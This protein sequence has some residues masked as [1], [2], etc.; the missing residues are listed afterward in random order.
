MMRPTIG[1]MLAALAV[2]CASAPV[3][4]PP[5]PVVPFEQ[6]ISWVVRL[7]D[8]RM[9]AD[10]LPPPPDEPV[11][12]QDSRTPVIAAAPP[13]GPDLLRLL[14]DSEARVRRR[15][16]LAVGRVGLPAGVSPLLALLGDNEPEVRQMAA[17]AL[18]L[19]GDPSAT[20]P[21]LAALA[22]PSPLVQG[23]AAEALG[24]IGDPT[25]ADAIADLAAQ[26]VDS[27]ALLTIPSD[28]SDARRDAPESVYRLALYALARLGNY[29]AL[30]RAALDASGQPVVRWWPVAYALQR[31]G[32]PRALPALRSLASDPHPYTRSF[33]V[34]ALGA[35]KDRESVPLLLP[36]VVGND[37]AVAIQAVEALGSIGD[38]DAASALVHIIQ[39][40]A[41]EPHLRLAAISAVGLVRGEGATDV[42]IDV[43]ADRSPPIRAAAL[44]S[45]A[46]L[47][48]QGFV[49][50]LSGLDPDSHWS[51]RAALA[52]TLAT[53]KAE[54]A[55]PRLQS[56]L[57]DGDQRVI[58][59]VLR[60]LTKLRAPNVAEVLAT[61]LRSDD[62]AVRAAA[63]AGIGELL[64]AEGSVALIEAYRGA[65][66]GPSPVARK[67]ILSALAR[68]GASLATPV[69]TEALEDEDWSVRRHAAELLA[70]FEPGTDAF[71]HIRPAPTHWGADIY[72]APRV[73]NPQV[74][75]QVYVE[76]E[77]GIIQIE[78]AVLD[79]PLTVENFIAL[80]SG[81]WYDGMPFHRVVAGH[82]VQ[83]GD[84][85]GDGEGGPGYTIRDELNQLPFL[86]GAVGMALNGPDS[87]GSQF[88]IALSPQPH[89][90]GRFTVFGRVLSGMEIVDQIEP[91]DVIRRVR[92]WDGDTLTRN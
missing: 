36:M 69:L 74:S 9:L 53:L 32:D 7:E 24:L 21:L 25:A 39:D 11:V 34:R 66:T 10:P 65:R 48:P 35:L 19:I 86:R 31:I 70:T 92:I 3:L 79:A 72:E 76:T 43:L 2:G 20:E 6:K 17:F 13:P 87:G 54:A 81:G 68:Y 83:H 62:V 85:R 15:A 80:A 45:L 63:A 59:S 75:T 46:R 23:S 22:D 5:Q 12:V 8:Q 67:A 14:T 33:A 18:G 82:V 91:W 40:P 30:A 57:D 56:M 41:S 29:Q 50:I 37:R 47:D 38:A 26:L 52:E 73:V 60:A 1:A 90:N 16:A 77:H 71:T 28:D 44:A 88:L 64:P 89:L 27:G 58:A 51:V 84:P 49:F 61:H 55:L 42:M 78:L 4:P